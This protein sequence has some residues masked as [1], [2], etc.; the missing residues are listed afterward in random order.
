MTTVNVQFDPRAEEIAYKVAELIRSE[1]TKV[2][3]DD[4]DRYN[5]GREVFEA[6]Y[7]AY[8]AAKFNG[9]K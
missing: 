8:L 3:T 7:F 2:S 4:E 5:V 9:D 1:A 6:L